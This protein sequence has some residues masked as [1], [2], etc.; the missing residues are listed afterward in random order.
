MAAPR[1]PRAFL[2]KGPVMNRTTRTLHVLGRA[3]AIAA[4]AALT[5]IA[6]PGAAS[7]D[8]SVS[9]SPD[10]TR[11]EGQRATTPAGERGSR[12]AR[13]GMPPRFEGGETLE[14]RG[15]LSRVGGGGTVVW[16]AAQRFRVPSTASIFGPRGEIWSRSDLHADQTVE[17]RAFLGKGANRVAEQIRVV[18]TKPVVGPNDLPTS[19]AVQG[20]SIVSPTEAK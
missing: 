12:G 7:A 10:G 19:V 3:A 4:A 6:A 20:M 18:N 2:T 16:L 8:R 5:L 14:V 15:V 11:P 17:M 1:E 9:R 13:T